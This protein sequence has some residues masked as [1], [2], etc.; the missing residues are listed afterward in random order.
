MTEKIYVK[1]H[2]IVVPGDLLVEG[3]DFLPAGKAFRKDD[4]VFASTIG[5]VSVKGHVVKVIPLA[6][7]YMPR[8]GDVVIGKVTGIGHSGWQLEVNSPYPADLNIGEASSE[9]IDLNKTDMTFYF[10]VGD[11]VLCEVLNISE[12]KFIKLTAKYRPYRRLKGGNIIEVSPTKIPRIIGK[13]GSMIK[14]MKDLT[15]C[16]VTVGQNGLIWIG[17]APDKQAVVARA[18]K[19]IEQEAH[20]QGLTDKVKEM[21][22]GK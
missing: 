7:K 19:F 9:Y 18:I 17:G 12:G 2:D 3:L 21:L 4:K 1:D 13:Q 8:K 6:G 20:K 5:I 16:D 22:S 11:Y 14:T 10:D 15:G